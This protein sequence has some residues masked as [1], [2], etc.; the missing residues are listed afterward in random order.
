MYLK[1]VENPALCSH[2]PTMLQGLQLA[3][4]SNSHGQSEWISCQD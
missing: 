2:L 1:A 3:L 4:V